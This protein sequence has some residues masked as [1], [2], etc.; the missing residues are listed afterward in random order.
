[1]AEPVEKQ[2]SESS[3]NDDASISSRNAIAADQEK[4]MLGQTP[5]PNQL[6]VEPA[7]LTRLDSQV[8]K[9]EKEPEDED[10]FAHLPEHEAA[11]L[12]RQVD[13][14]PVKV[15]YF[16]LYRYATRNDFLIMLLSGFCAIVGGA[17]MPLMTVRAYPSH[18]AIETNANHLEDRLWNTSRHLSGIFPWSYKWRRL[19]AHH[20]SPRTVFCVSRD[21][22]VHHN[23]YSHGWIHLHW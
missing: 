2:I 17:V 20:Q 19:P 7:P 13:I 11:I 9:S 14:P 16:M 6:P 4:A 22:R 23:L 5:F 8:P 21:C 15:T 3:S 18:W 12:K 10:P 1:M